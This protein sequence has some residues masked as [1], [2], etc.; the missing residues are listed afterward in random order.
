MKPGLKRKNKKQAKEEA[1]GSLEEV[2][3]QKLHAIEFFLSKNL[4][5]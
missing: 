5:F 3:L 4:C 2:L 1:N